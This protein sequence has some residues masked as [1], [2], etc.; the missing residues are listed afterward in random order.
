MIHGLEHIA[1]NTATMAET[2][3]FY[4]KH[5]GAKTVRT[6]FLEGTGQELTYLQMGEGVI[7]ELLGFSSK[8]DVL[9]GR[10]PVKKRLPG[11]NHIAFRVD[12]LDEV[13]AELSA[14]QVSF[15]VLPRKAVSGVGRI[16][17]LIDPNTIEIELLEQPSFRLRASET[18][19][20]G[21]HSFE[22]ILYVADIRASTDFY[23]ANFHFNQLE[24][25]SAGG[26]PATYL[27]SP[28]GN[29]E[30]IE[31]GGSEIGRQFSENPIVT[32]RVADVGREVDRLAQEN[33]RVLQRPRESG[34]GN[35]EYGVVCDAE[36]NKI[37]I[38]HSRAR[39]KR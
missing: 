32:V 24:Q 8:T 16:A 26:R 19:N 22:S 18:P 2:V 28:T 11:F 37:K 20:R 1:I 23:V 27:E 39:G 7:I 25:C 30:L 38:A 3:H 36:G 6:A 35:T 29:L 14:R 5:F 13:F 10:D 12:G 15:K 31:V 9:P 17:F 21:T 34:P 33:V 4:E